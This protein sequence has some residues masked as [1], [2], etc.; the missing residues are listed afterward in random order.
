MFSIRGYGDDFYTGGTSDKSQIIMGLLCPSLVAYFFSPNGWLL[1]RE[2]R[3]WHYP[4]PGA[5]GEGY[6]IYDERFQTRL[7]E[8]MRG[9]MKDIGFLARPICVEAF[10]D[11]EFSVGIADE[12]DAGTVLYWAKEYYLSSDGE[13]EST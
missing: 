4:A 5:Q 13:V 7:G 1:G 6:D 11:E 8:Q 9:W 10:A 2:V 12:E 3:P